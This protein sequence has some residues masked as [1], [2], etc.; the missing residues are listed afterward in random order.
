MYSD[1]LL[2]VGRGMNA[3]FAIGRLCDLDIG[4]KS[5]LAL[6]DSEKM[7]DIKLAFRNKEC[8]IQCCCLVYC[9]PLVVI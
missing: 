1:Y 3:A 4:R 5:L 2:I 8:D 9:D 6:P 7:V